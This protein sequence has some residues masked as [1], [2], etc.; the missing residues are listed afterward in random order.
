MTIALLITTFN[1]P[2]YLQKC[3]SSLKYADLSQLS[4]ILI[5]DDGSTDTETLIIIDSFAETLGFD[6]INVIKSAENE[7]IKK[8]LLLGYELLFGI[9]YDNNIC[10]RRKFACDIVINLD[11]DAIVRK[12]F[13]AKLLEAYAKYS[14]KSKIITGFHSTTKN[15]NGS[16]RHLIIDRD[17]LTYLKRSVGGINICIDKEVYIKAVKPALLMPGNWDHNACLSSGGAYCLKESVI[18]HIGF[19]SSMNHTE[20]PDVADDFYFHHIDN[21]T[22]LCVDGRGGDYINFPI[23]KSAKRIKFAAVVKLTPPIN[24]VEQYS[25]FVLKESYKYITTTHCLIVQSDG[26]VVNPEAWQDSWLQYDYIGAPWWYKDEYNVGNGGFSLRS[27]RL[28]EICA[29]D[30]VINLTHPEDHHICRTYRKYL[31]ETYMISFA[32]ENVASIFSYEGY[33]QKGNKFDGQ[34][35]FHGKRYLNVEKYNSKKMCVINQFRGLGDILFLVPLVRAIINNGIEVTWPIHP[36]YISIA[37]HFPDI[38]MVDMQTIDIDYRTNVQMMTRYGVVLPYRYA[39]EIMKRKMVD[40]MRSKYELYGH[41]YLMWRNLTWKRFP[42]KEQRLCDFLRL[43]T[44]FILLNRHFAEAKRSMSI[45]PEIK[46]TLPIIEM[47]TIPEYSLIDWCSVI[48]RAT[49]IHTANTSLLY[50]LEIMPLTMPIHLY[51]RGISGENAFEHTD[52]LYTKPYI[53]H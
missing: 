1:R 29:G 16:E 41:S 12:D 4:V 2:G 7:G 50:I 28:L 46:S 47:E 52:Y 22:L 35:G 27:K 20:R 34:F 14:H 53:L 40:C 45:V 39:M 43:P 32:P 33:K 23:L 38:N 26:Y 10:D 48:E 6:N 18:D 21:V 17:E 36:E 51:R 8:S 9:D 13:V 11:S 5:I 42:D 37:K 44:K 24:N 30:P 25:R 19:K 49:E 15:A 3:L 31:E